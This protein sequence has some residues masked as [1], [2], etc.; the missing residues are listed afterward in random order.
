MSAKPDEALRNVNQHIPGLLRATQSLRS[1]F[2]T[3]GRIGRQT[4]WFISIG[5][6][7]AL[8]I[9]ILIAGS[10]G[11]RSFPIVVVPG[12]AIFL[13]AKLATQASDGTIAANPAGW[14]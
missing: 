13:W 11:E 3:Q 12:F 2:S 5:L 14:C 1:L 9:N 7:V 4:F 8:M 10:L 6:F